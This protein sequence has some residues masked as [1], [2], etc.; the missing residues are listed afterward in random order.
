MAERPAVTVTAIPAHGV[1]AKVETSPRPRVL[2]RSAAMAAPQ[3]VAATM[4]AIAIMRFMFSAPVAGRLL[5][6]TAALAVRVT[7]TARAYL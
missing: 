5:L 3:H 4:A 1:A 6:L 2:P 7:Q